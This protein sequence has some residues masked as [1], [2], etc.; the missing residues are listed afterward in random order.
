MQGFYGGIP[1]R[2]FL[3]SK[4]FTSIDDLIEDVKNNESDVEVNN[5]VVIDNIIDNQY[6]GSLWIKFYKPASIIPQFKETIP[7]VVIDNTYGYGYIARISGPQGIQGIQGIPG[8]AGQ[9]G[10]K[11]DIGKTGPEGPRG[12]SLEIRGSISINDY[13]SPEDANSIVITMLT[14]KYSN[15]TSSQVFAVSFPI[16]GSSFWYFK[17]TDEDWQYI[18]ANGGGG[19]GTFVEEMSEEDINAIII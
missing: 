5:Y 19:G 17:T 1:G 16:S 9:K 18:S 8:E 7:S 14:E 4:T 12:E 6:H 3:I 11:G 2:D 13:E 10:D 15:I